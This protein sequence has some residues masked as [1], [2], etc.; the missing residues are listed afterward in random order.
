MPT[1]SHAIATAEL[2][3]IALREG[4]AMRPLHFEREGYALQ[5]KLE[6]GTI[7]PRHRHTG[8][9]HAINLSGHREIIGDG[10]IIGPG[11]F[12]FEPAGNVDSWRCHGDEPCIVQISLTGRVEYLSDDG[13][14]ESYS[15]SETALAAY[16]E[17]CA[18]N[19]ISP[20]QRI[21]GEVRR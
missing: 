3:W 15:D 20:D 12:I 16:L 2:P 11:D 1:A 8:V 10:E 7:I 19:G 21:I 4:L 5:L 13:A 17:H 14:I 6:P 9:V 18:G